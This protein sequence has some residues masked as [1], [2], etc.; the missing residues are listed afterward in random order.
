V[1]KAN[2]KLQLI[3]INRHNKY[4]RKYCIN[5]H[6]IKQL[7]IRLHLASIVSYYR[8][9][10]TIFLQALVRR[11]QYKYADMFQS[12]W[13]LTTV[14]RNYHRDGCRDDSNNETHNAEMITVKIA[15]L[16]LINTG[17][18]NTA[19]TVIRTQYT[20]KLLTAHLHPASTDPHY[21]HFLTIFLAY[22]Q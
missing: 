19:N 2:A 10:I 16:Q 22:T 21:R 3:N 12:V 11:R 14:G 13:N 17:T 20:I 4:H 5:M 7:T 6:T 1:Q 18:T 8:H 9:F 15:K